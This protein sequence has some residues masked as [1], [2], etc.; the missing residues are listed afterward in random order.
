[1]TK[2]VIQ[3]HY[4]L[5]LLRFELIRWLGSKRKELSLQE[6]IE[7]LNT[8]TG[9]SVCNETNYTVQQLFQL[10]ARS[11]CTSDRHIPPRLVSGERLCQPTLEPAEESLS[12]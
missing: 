3:N 2:K 11:L 8:L 9:R 10:V 4:M 1:M 12:D 5:Q 6:K 7:M